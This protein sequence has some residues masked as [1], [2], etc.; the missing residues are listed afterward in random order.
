M[1]R[2]ILAMYQLTVAMYRYIGAMYLFNGAF[3]RSLGARGES[4]ACSSRLVV[5]AHLF[6]VA[7]NRNIA[8]FSW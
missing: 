7:S 5:A 4:K 3:P 6:A 2:V 1:H 8:T